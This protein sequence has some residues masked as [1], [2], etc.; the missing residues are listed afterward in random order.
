M[1][2]II[3]AV[4]HNDDTLALSKSLKRLTD[5][6]DQVVILGIAPRLSN[7]ITDHKVVS[8]AKRAEQ[9]LLNALTEKTE[10]LSQTVGQACDVDLVS[11]PIAQ[12]II[13]TTI[14]RKA[15]LVVKED[16]HLSASSKGR[17]GNVARTLLKRSPSTTLILRKPIEILTPRIVIA[18]DNPENKLEGAERSLL[19]ARVFKSGIEMAKR[20]GA[21]EVTLLHIWTM[22]DLK[23][24]QHPRSGLSEEGVNQ[25]IAK[26]K[27]VTSKWFNAFR[28][29]AEAKYAPEGL[30]FRTKLVLGEGGKALAEAADELRPDLLVIGS[31]NRRG[32]QSLFFGNTAEDVLNWANC[33]LL[34]VK[35]VDFYDMVS[36]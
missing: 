36:A 2:T 10:N 33:N 34:V 6:D 16:D 18:I 29:E 27:A 13:E 26:A 22:P 12:K 28:Q 15:D 23:F 1:A 14:L 9:A 8:S 20:L 32:V 7:E 3:G 5:G 25:H 31:A 21:E 11:G 24:L 35:P 17:I 30:S 4:D 19:N